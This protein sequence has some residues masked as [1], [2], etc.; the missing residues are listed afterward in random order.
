MILFKTRGH[1]CS[2]VFLPF[3]ILSL[4]GENNPY[5][6]SQVEKLLEIFFNVYIFQNSMSLLDIS[7]D[8]RVHLFQEGLATTV[9]LSTP[10]RFDK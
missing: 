8:W 5:I 2:V 6:F 1:T 9:V 7:L 4:I 10:P 3:Y